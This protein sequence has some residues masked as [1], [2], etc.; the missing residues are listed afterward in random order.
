LLGIPRDVV[1]EVIE[2]HGSAEL[3]RERDGGLALG[4]EVF[5]IMGIQGLVKFDIYIYLSDTTRFLIKSVG[6]D[7][8]DAP[9]HS[10]KFEPSGL[11]YDEIKALPHSPLYVSGHWEAVREVFVGELVPFPPQWM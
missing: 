6:S 11:M 1:R 9:V 4:D 10:I 2:L 8:P 3:K 5:D 7:R